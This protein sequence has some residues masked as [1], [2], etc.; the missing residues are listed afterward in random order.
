MTAGAWIRKIALEY[1]EAAEYWRTDHQEIKRMKLNGF[2]HKDHLF[3]D[4]VVGLG[5]AFILWRWDWSATQDVKDVATLTLL[6]CWWALA[7][8]VATTSCERCSKKKIHD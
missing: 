2:T 1:R 3:A 5:F 6:A 4:A 8:L 7:L